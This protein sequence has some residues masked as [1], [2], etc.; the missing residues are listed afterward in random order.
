MSH[1]IGLLNHAVQIKNFAD[2]RAS[3]KLKWQKPKAKIESILTCAKARAKKGISI[4][5]CK[6]GDRGLVKVDATNTLPM[7]YFDNYGDI[8]LVYDPVMI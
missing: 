7:S 4:Y 6:V 8:R 5:P 1:E 3:M 2:V